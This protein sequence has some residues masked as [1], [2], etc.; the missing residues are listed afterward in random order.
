MVPATVT[1]PRT[2]RTFFFAL[3]ANVDGAAT[4]NASFACGGFGIVKCVRTSTGVLNPSSIA[5][6]IVYRPGAVAA[7]LPTRETPVPP[8]TAVGA[9]LSLVT[10][11]LRHVTR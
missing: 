10:V 8:A 11:T 3:G 5:A 2:L 9:P 6:R 1:L 7:K 4:D